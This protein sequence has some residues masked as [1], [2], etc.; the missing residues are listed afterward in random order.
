MPV[1]LLIVL[2]IAVAIFFFCV[3]RIIYPNLPWWSVM[4]LGSINVP[5]L[6]LLLIFGAHY[7]KLVAAFSRRLVRT[8]NAILA[9]YLLGVLR[10]FNYRLILSHTASAL[11]GLVVVAF[12]FIFG[13]Q[14]GDTITKMLPGRANDPA[15]ASAYPPKGYADLVPF[16]LIMI[17]FALVPLVAKY[18]F[19]GYLVK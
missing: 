6:F 1:P 11:S 13:K 7:L 4:L 9:L 17:L 5:I 12:F 18:V 2:H 16:T 10:F 19:W 8:K 14:I 3:D 15:L